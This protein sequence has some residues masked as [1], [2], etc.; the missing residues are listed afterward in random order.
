MPFVV[1]T[2]PLVIGAVLPAL[3]PHDQANLLGGTDGRDAVQRLDVDEPEA[4]H[5][6]EEARARRPGAIDERLG[7]AAD[8]H[9]VVG[10]QPM[11]AA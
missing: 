3:E 5:F 11:A 9:D 4:A 7:A 10:D 2:E 1:E 6:H 8:V